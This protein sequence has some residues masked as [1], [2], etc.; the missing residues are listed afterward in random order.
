MPWSCFEMFL[1]AMEPAIQE[2]VETYIRHLLMPAN[3]TGDA[4]HL[5]IAAYYRREFPLDLEL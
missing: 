5:A 1:L 2:I 3:P 4:L